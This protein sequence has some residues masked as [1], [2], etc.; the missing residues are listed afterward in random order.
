MWNLSVFVPTCQCH[1]SCSDCHGLGH[2][3]HVLCATE[4]LNLVMRQHHTQ[5][6]QVICVLT[7]AWN[8][9]AAVNGNKQ[10]WSAFGLILFV[11][12]QGLQP[13]SCW[14]VKWQRL[15]PQHGRAQ[16]VDIEIATECCV[17][18][19]IV[20]QAPTTQTWRG[21]LLSKT[22]VVGLLWVYPSKQA[23]SVPT[24]SEEKNHVFHDQIFA[25]PRNQTKHK[26]SNWSTQQ[27]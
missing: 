9:D 7:K 12:L 18:I 4:L 27:S 14:H 25:L 22:R 26:Q 24:N 19:W 2:A 11:T 3:H 21:W 6:S 23:G 17:R 10:T 5:Q 1:L 15:H 16:M 8:S 13:T 20:H